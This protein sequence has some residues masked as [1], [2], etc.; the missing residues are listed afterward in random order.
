MKLVL[1]T[2]GTLSPLKAFTEELQIR[3][4]VQ[5]ENP[6]IIKKN[7]VM[8]GV[9]NKGPNGEQINSAYRNREWA[10]AVL[11]SSQLEESCS[12]T[13]GR[14]SGTLLRSLKM[15]NRRVSDSAVPI[16]PMAGRGN[17]YHSH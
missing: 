16:S 1:I 9:I 3:F 2:S 12:R 4:P 7:Q 5:L 10:A 15:R 8:V 13:L 11:T 14:T 6:H 17:T